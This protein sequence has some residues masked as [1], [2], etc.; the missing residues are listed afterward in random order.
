MMFDCILG[1]PWV[2]RYFWGDS[3]NEQ[4]LPVTNKTETYDVLS[5]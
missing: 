3:N 4:I 2:V 1:F 5:T